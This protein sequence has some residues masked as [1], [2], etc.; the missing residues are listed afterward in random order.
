MTN[1]ES[2]GRHGIINI[3]QQYASA[4]K[5]DEKRAWG[6]P[7]LDAVTFSNDDCQEASPDRAKQSSPFIQHED[8]QQSNGRLI[9]RI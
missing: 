2:Y 3:E 7:G 5:L 8:H 9:A 6:L 4:S 1:R